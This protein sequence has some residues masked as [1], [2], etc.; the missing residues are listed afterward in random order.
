MNMTLFVKRPQHVIEM[1]ELAASGDLDLNE[2]RSAF[3]KQTGKGT[4]LT[5]EELIVI[6]ASQDDD[7]GV[8]DLVKRM[9]AVEAGQQL[10]WDGEQP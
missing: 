9:K 10:E 6:H 1:R 8:N 7:Y 3:Q 4:K 2:A 5:D